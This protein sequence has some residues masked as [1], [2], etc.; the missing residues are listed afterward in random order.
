MTDGPVIDGGP[1]P[2][3]VLNHGVEEIWVLGAR[4]VEDRRI[5]L[6]LRSTT[7]GTWEV[8]GD[9]VFGALMQLRELVEPL[10][11]MLCC[12]G[13]RL[14]AWS[15]GMLRSMGEGQ[16]VYLLPETDRTSKPPVVATLGCAD[17]VEVVGVADQRAWFE[18]WLP[19]SS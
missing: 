12:N 18:A 3:T 8:I 19:E 1:A 9:D 17:P 10:G 13:A 16:S 2:I 4:R 14:N 7:N 5:E 6:A 15:S 11:V